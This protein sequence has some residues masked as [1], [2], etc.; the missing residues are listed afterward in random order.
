M[1][2]NYNRKIIEAINRFNESFY[3]EVIVSYL[4]KNKNRDLAFLFGG[5][6]CLTCGMFDYFIDFSKILSEVMGEQYIVQDKYPLNE[7]YDGWIVVFRKG[8]GIGYHEEAGKF[9]IIDPKTGKIKRK[10]HVRDIM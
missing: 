8:K 7:G 3:P 9:I 10:I 1:R 2:N 5:H 4:G 6:F